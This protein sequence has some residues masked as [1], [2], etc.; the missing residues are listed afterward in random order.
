MVRGAGAREDAAPRPH[1][2]IF[3]KGMMPATP[4]GATPQLQ[5]HLSLRPRRVCEQHAAE[6][7]MKCITSQ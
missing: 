5:T 4:S 1:V 7:V 3:V 2:L 6:P